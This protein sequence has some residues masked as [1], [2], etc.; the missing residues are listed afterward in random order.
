MISR[1]PHPPAGSA[2]RKRRGVTLLELLVVV[3]LLGVTA[4]VA[5]L[6]M[7][8]RRV[9]PDDTPH[10]IANARA[11]ALRTGRPVTVV[12]Q[13]DST[14]SIAT[15]MPDGTVLADPTTGIDRLTGYP[16]PA[17]DT[18]ARRAGS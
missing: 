4:S 8:A 11:Q 2:A 3:T 10:R 9:P 6:V 17:T 7:P 1:A 5:V 13:L 15:A 18:T 16:L 12:L 14:Y